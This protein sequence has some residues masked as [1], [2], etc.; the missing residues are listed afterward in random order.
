[1]SVKKSKTAIV[2]FL[3][4]QVAVAWAGHRAWTRV[5]TWYRPPSAQ[6]AH[7]DSPPANLQVIAVTDA[8]LEVAETMLVKDTAVSLSPTE[9]SRLIGASVTPTADMTFYLLRAVYLNSE[10]GSYYVSQRG[11]ELEVHHA[12]LGRHAVPMKRGAVIVQLHQPPTE[13]YVTCSMAE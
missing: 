5:D 9:A 12:C 10:T 2:L 8:Q 4:A 1:M 7:S 13:V 11:H 3:G 6:W